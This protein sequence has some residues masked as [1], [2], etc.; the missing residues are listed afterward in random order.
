MPIQNL[1][2]CNNHS[3]N[4]YAD[5][6]KRLIFWFFIL[7]VTHILAIENLP[8]SK[9]NP[10]LLSNYWSAKWI[11]WPDDSGL[12]YGVYHFRKNFELEEI[13]GEFI[14]HVTADNRY[15]LF[16]NGEPV[17][18]GPARGDLMH[19]RYE[20]I[21][22]SSYLKKGEN[23]IAA[24]VWNFAGLKP[25]AQHSLRTAFLLQGNSENEKAVN[26]NS[27]WKVVKNNAVQPANASRE[28]TGGSFIVVGP[29]DKVDA[30][31][32]PWDW[33]KTEF[34]D[35]DW[36]QAKILDNGRPKEAGSGIAWGLEPRE[37]P[38]MEA[39]KQ[40]FK[41]IRRSEN[42]RIDESFLERKEHVTIPA[43]RKV[44]VLF[45]QRE[46]TTAYPN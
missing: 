6:M 25:W 5:I 12:E 7:S 43:N 29:C 4:I 40:H 10:D 42:I 15:R 38:L 33:E 17:C 9:I 8:K 41:A 19:W 31:N 27:L 35:S 32:Y 3:K 24:V 26:T 21:N 28:E 18:F 46:L 20:S 44:V 39:R 30:S 16:V 36:K 1:W 13:P 2:S 34:N 22:I 45:D 14:I 37:I 11:A 23:L